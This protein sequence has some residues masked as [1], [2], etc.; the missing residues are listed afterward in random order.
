M[1]C[2]F[3][4]T[5][6]FIKLSILCS[7]IIRLSCLLFSPRNSDTKTSDHCFQ[8]NLDTRQKE[9]YK[10]SSFGEQGPGAK[11]VV[12]DQIRFAS[13]ILINVDRP[14]KTLA[15]HFRRAMCNAVCHL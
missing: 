8:P 3:Y 1:D 6:D 15:K 10:L 7:Q 11:Y 2:V 5:S 13:P 14:G 9:K 12:C 4:I